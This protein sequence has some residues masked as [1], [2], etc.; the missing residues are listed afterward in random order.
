LGLWDTAGQEDYDRLRPLSYPGTNV[1][2]IC[3]SVVSQAS[4]DNVTEKWHPEIKHHTQN[5]PIVIIGTKFDLRENEEYC[6]SLKQNGESVVQKSQGEELMKKIKAYGFRECSA[7]TDRGIKEVFED[8]IRAG[9]TS[10][11][12]T[13]KKGGCMVL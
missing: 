4:F 2:L 9:Q 7:K 5:V 11:S 3:Y 10:P 8:A 6:K 1:F 12:S 13:A